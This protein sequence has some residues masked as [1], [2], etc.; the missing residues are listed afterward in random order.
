MKKQRMVQAAMAGTL[1]VLAACGNENVDE[2]GAENQSQN[3]NDVNNAA[4]EMN[5]ADQEPVTIK[6][7]NW[8]NDV[9]AQTS[10]QYIADFE[11]EYP[12]ITVES[13]SMVPGDS[14]GTLQN[15]DILLSSGEKVDV[16]SFPNVDSLYQRA[17][18]GALAPLDE[19]YDNEG[20]TPNDEYFI[21]PMVNDDYYGIQYNATLNFMMLNKDAFDEA[22]LDIPD[23]SWTWA[24][25]EEYAGQLV[26]KE[27]DNQRYGA[28]F[29]TWPLYMN[30]PAQTL[31][32]HPFLY[33]DGTTNFADESF[34]E[35]FAMRERLETE[36]ITKTY[37]ESLGADLGY[38]TEYFNENASMLLTGSWMIGEA[39][40]TDLN[41]HDFTTAFAPVPVLNE[42]DPSEYYM[43][44]NFF[45]IGNTSEYKDEAYLFARHVST[46]LSDSRSELPGWKKGDPQPVVERMID[47]NEDQIDVDS[48]MYTLFGDDISYLDASQI[49]ITYAGEL[50][51]ILVD[52]FGMYMLDNEPLDE[53]QAWMVEEATKVIDSYNE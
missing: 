42:G 51:S 45:G 35:M 6:W 15:L 16:I 14:L 24:D 19:F 12:H 13:I 2:A 50:D 33:E 30:P 9:M 5:E 4:E 8:D 7:Y 41:P 29:H 22:G 1:V 39:G 26:N 18:M 38:R 11:E 47:G 37:A 44:G 48:L 27:G 49:S 20:I 3:E 31:M 32:K 53:V 34:P 52:G 17:E 21:N 28:Y 46:N 36:G 10:E 40:D 23:A 43:G 25:F